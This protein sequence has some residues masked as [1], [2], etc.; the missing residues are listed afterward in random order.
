VLNLPKAPPL[1]DFL[2]L[3]WRRFEDDRCMQIASSLTFTTL[4]AIVPIITIA[5]TLITAFPVFAELTKQLE[6]F[7]V[8]NVLPESARTIVLYTQEFAENA[9]KLT[10]LGLFFLFVTSIIVLMT[11]D[12][13]FNEIWRVPRPRSTFQ[14]VVIYWTLLTL[15]PVLIGASLS[16]TSWVVSVS[17][18]VVKD[19]PYAGKLLLR[20]VP[21]ILTACAFAL[22]YVTLPNRRVLV[23]D[24]LTGGFLAAAAF[25]AMKFGFAIYITQFPT[26]TL[27]YGAFA[28][29]PIFLLWIYLSWLVVV[30][31]AAAT[32]V[33]PEWRERTSHSAAVPGSQ[34]LDA[35]QV[36]RMLWEGSLAGEVVRERRLH[37][38]V[39]LPYDQLEAI[40]DTMREA[41]WVKR[42]SGGWALAR[43]AP[44]ISVA[45]VYRQFVFRGGDEPRLRQ[46][47]HGLDQ[48]ASS[49][50]GDLPENFQVSLAEL[51]AR[52]APEKG[53]AEE[54]R[55]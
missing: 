53:G 38:A 2:R 13:A 52:A 45:E 3:L 17:M 49:L 40:L 43:G 51:F 6:T 14:R 46:S 44:A 54:A 36:L 47:G 42:V 25:E 33:L 20:I 12:Q 15:G 5:L 23:R 4:L 26:Y 7:L 29:V 28:A 18:G 35:L 32:A 37:G 27:V 41:G 30:L 24:A 1:L 48:L 21:M 10:A 9:A 34:F 19:I 8:E 11:I 16:L 39:K 55:E 50:A 22:L 31:G